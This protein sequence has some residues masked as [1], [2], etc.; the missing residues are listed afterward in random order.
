M[1]EHATALPADHPRLDDRMLWDHSARTYLAWFDQGREEFSAEEQE[2][3]EFY[4]KSTKYR[5]CTRADVS[6][7]LAQSTFD[8]TEELETM[9][10]RLRAELKQLQI[11]DVS[12]LHTSP[13]D[14]SADA[15][16]T[17]QEAQ[18]RLYP[19]GG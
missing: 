13:I 11:E 12:R 5:G 4:G 16:A 9:L 15:V 19:L 10:A 14:N 3:E 6:E 2:L 7:K 8:E 1:L 17:A 18:R